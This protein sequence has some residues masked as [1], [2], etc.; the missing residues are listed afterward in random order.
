MLQRWLGNIAGVFARGKLTPTGGYHVIIPDMLNV[1]ACSRTAPS[2]LEFSGVHPV[3][4][5]ID[6]NFG[7][8]AR[9]FTISPTNGSGVNMATQWKIRCSKGC[10]TEWRVEDDFISAVKSKGR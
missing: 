2:V 3:R 5:T 10:V 6:L 1:L 9:C 8:A 7:T 4:R